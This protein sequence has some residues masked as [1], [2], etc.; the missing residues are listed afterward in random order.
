MASFKEEVHNLTNLPLARRQYNHS[1]NFHKALVADTALYGK[2]SEGYQCRDTSEP[3]IPGSKEKWADP[4]SHPASVYGPFFPGYCAAALEAAIQ[5]AKTATCT[6][7]KCVCPRVKKGFIKFKCCWCAKYCFD[8]PFACPRHAD[9]EEAELKN[10]R[11]AQLER[12]E[13]LLQAELN[14]TDFA[15]EEELRTTGTET[16][17]KILRQVDIAGTVYAFYS[18]VALFFPAPLNVFRMPLAVTVKRYLFGVEKTAFILFVLAVWWGVD[19]FQRVFFSPEFRVYIKNILRDPCI[20]DTDFI[21]ARYQVVADVCDE[22]I[23]MQPEFSS[24]VLTIDHVLSEVGFFVG[25]C[26][27][28][29]PNRNLFNFATPDYIPL[30]NASAIG[31]GRSLNLRCQDNQDACSFMLPNEDIEFVGNTTLCVENDFT[32]SLISSPTETSA[33]WWELWF[34]TGLFAQILIKFVIVNYGVALY[35]WADPLGSCGG[36]CLWPHKDLFV[37][38]EDQAEDQQ[39]GVD[40]KNRGGAQSQSP[41][42]GWASWCLCCYGILPLLAKCL[43]WLPKLL[44]RLVFGDDIPNR[45]K[46]NNLKQLRDDNEMYLRVIARKW[47]IIWGLLANCCIFNLMFAEVT[48]NEEDGLT[49]VVD[50]VWVCLTLFA[51]ILIPATLT[52]YIRHRIEREMMTTAANDDGVQHVGSLPTEP[53]LTTDDARSP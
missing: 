51:M 31:F 24:S 22:L 39:Q 1:V 28:A 38:T 7:Q 15:F 52:L 43:L 16:A 12:A 5:A 9:E 18:A 27:C 25:S 35:R 17:Q 49:E 45:A 41:T 19:Y 37:E 21:M 50:T 42:Q 47:S 29:F 32:D 23:P 4:T 30:A 6:R 8:I 44:W 11:V 14:K 10:Y 48:G 34:S 36:Q 20:L 2:E 40:A 46:T 13:E 53:V 26:D 33:E 3:S